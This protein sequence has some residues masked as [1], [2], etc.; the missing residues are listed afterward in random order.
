MTLTSTTRATADTHAARILFTWKDSKMERKQLT[1]ASHQQCIYRPRTKIISIYLM[2][3]KFCLLLNYLHM[4][5]R[6]DWCP[7]VWSGFWWDC[8]AHSCRCFYPDIPPPEVERDW[9]WDQTRWCWTINCFLCTRRES[10]FS[11]STLNTAVNNSGLLMFQMMKNTVKSLW[12]WQEQA[13]E[14]EI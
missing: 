4:C 7:D 8:W 2:K 3:Q 5:D 14:L 6:V 13:D 12:W 1:L 9:C 11:H 10:H